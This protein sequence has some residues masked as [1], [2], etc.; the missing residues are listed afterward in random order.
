MSG[1]CTPGLHPSCRI[2]LTTVFRCTTY[3]YMSEV[4][5]LRPSPLIM[6]AWGEKAMVLPCGS[7]CFQLLSA[8]LHGSHPDSPLPSK[9]TKG[10]SFTPPA[11][12]ISITV[13][14]K[15]SPPGALPRGMSL[16]DDTTLTFPS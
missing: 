3:W 7:I 2:S 12:Q 14:L 4:L 9:I 15:P 5:Q 11:L 13:I 8:Y 1:S 16:P 10:G 6:L